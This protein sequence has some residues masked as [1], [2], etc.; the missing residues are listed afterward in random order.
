MRVLHLYKDYAPVIGGIENHIRLLAEGQRSLGIDARV[1]VTNTGRATVQETIDGVPAVKT[2]RLLNVSSAPISPAFYPWLYR[3]EE[4]IDI[5]HAHLPYPPGELG[6]LALGRSRRFVL[7]YHSDIVR[8]RVLG[9]LYAPLLRLVLRRADL[10]A[11]SNPAYIRLS[12]FLS[13]VSAKCRVIPFGVD[14]SRFEATPA[15]SAAAAQLKQRYGKPLLLFVGRFR[16]YK[17]V[18]VLLRAM[19]GIDAHLL[20]VGAG[21]MER[22]WRAQAEAEELLDKVTFGGE[23]SDEELVAAYHAADVFVLPSTNRAEAYGIV[24]MEAL[25]CG[26]PAVCTELGTGTSFV[27]QDG[28]TGFVVPPGDPDALA[29]AI[30]RLLDNAELRRTMASAATVRARAEFSKEAMLTRIVAFYQEA[31]TT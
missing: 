8:Q 1:L 30:V 19:Y 24:Q 20:L 12:P 11:V 6:H 23:F 2:G 26:L 5:A 27:N 21:P 25:A 22:T 13:S 3:L 31:L 16:H 7:S 29:A 28:V 9:A 17:G 14:L 4:G 15:V 10:I 18:D